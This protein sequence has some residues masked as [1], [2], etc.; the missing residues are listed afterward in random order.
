MRFQ[1]PLHYNSDLLEVLWVLA[2]LEVPLTKEI[3]IG[4]AKLLSLQTA[5]GNWVMKNSLNGKMWVDIEK[6]GKP[7]RWLT[8]KACEVLQ[9]YG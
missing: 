5:Q 2:K 7:S 8:M 3:E 6:K 1:F 9:F 4:I